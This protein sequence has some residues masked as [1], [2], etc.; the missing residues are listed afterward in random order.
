MIKRLIS[1]SSL[2]FVIFISSNLVANEASQARQ[3]E[4]SLDG[5]YQSADEVKPLLP[6]Q[7]VPEFT[8][9]TV[10]DKLFT[11]PKDA[12]EKPVVITFFR[13]GWCPYCNLHLSEF[14]KIEDDLK[15]K[16]FEVWFV[17][18]DKPELLYESLSE[19]VEYLLL[20]DAELSAS[21]AFG[22]G[23]QLDDAA[24][25]R[26][27]GYGIDLEETSGQTHHVLPAPATFI[28]GKDGKVH[29]QFVS[30]DTSIRL[31]PK[32]LLA[33]ADAYLEGATGRLRKK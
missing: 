27:Q 24:Y 18:L 7:E 15:E 6:G 10:D 22:I 14:R 23:Y 20:S 25:K 17:S 4:I 13:G 2:I 8:L 30:P 1:I 33:A 29:F 12:N 9:K 32:L 28:L 16:G 5:I 11:F 21:K 3:N 19:K 31:S 26:Y